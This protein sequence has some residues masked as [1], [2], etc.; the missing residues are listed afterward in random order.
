[1]GLV[2]LTGWFAWRS[3]EEA[4]RPHRLASSHKRIVCRLPATCPQWRHSEKGGHLP[5]CGGLEA[6]ALTVAAFGLH[7]S[8]HS[9]RHCYSK[10]FEAAWLR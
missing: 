7:T 6:H 8:T 5:S 3:C 1:M 2:L 10:L 4:A 9:G